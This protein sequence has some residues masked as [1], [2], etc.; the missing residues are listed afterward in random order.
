M[1][2]P[3]RWRDG[4]QFSMELQRRFALFD[5]SLHARQRCRTCVTFCIPPRSSNNSVSFA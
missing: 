2:P 5:A 1:F 3:F 4:S